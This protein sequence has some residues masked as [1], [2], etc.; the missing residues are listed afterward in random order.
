M[1]AAFEGEE[2]LIRNPESVRPWQHVLD[3]LCGYLTLAEKL[4]DDPDAFAESW[5]FGPDESETSSVLDV[6]GR[7]KELWG[8]GVSSRLDGRVHPHEAR[9]LNLDSS[10]A[11]TR[12]GWEPRWNLNSALR[13]TVQWYKAQQ[14]LR[15][16]HDLRA[17]TEEQIHFHQ[18]TLVRPEIVLR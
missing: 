5:N 17:F 13:A 7:L 2:L 9:H 8:P 15:A 1:R 18:A 16:S 10:K 4:F 6:L 11:K 14:N 3:P 12:L